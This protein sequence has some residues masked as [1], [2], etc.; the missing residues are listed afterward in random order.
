MFKFIQ[1]WPNWL[2][3]AVLVPGSFLVGILPIAL[4]IFF[5]KIGSILGSAIFSMFVETE[6]GVVISGKSGFDVY[7]VVIAPLLSGALLIL[8]LNYIAPLHKKLVV[9]SGLGV[10]IVMSI[11]AISITII[12]GDVIGMTVTMSVLMVVG[13]II[14]VYFLGYI[15]SSPYK[16]KD[17]DTGNKE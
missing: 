3:W 13:S 11:F 15:W 1:K 17:L 12:S 10:R 2:R 9:F 8:S 6:P 5:P 4:Y 7:R 16:S 14:T